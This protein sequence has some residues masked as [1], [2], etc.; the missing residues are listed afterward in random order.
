MTAL[1]ALLGL[2]VGLGVWLIV[3]G[4]SRPPTSEH[5]RRSRAKF[6]RRV[7]IRALVSVAVGVLV[8][9]A[10]GWVIG[11]VLT[12][13]AAFFLPRVLGPDREHAARVARFEAIA[14]WAEMLRDTL[15]AAAGLEQAILVTAPLVPDPIREPVMAAAG[16]LRSGGRLAP[17]LRELADELADPTADLVISALVLAAERRASN[18]GE[19]L[20][21]L[22]QAARDH[23]AL[24]MSVAA[25]RAQMRSEVRI[26]I[27]TTLCFAG[28]LLVLDRRYLNA[29]N[30]AAGQLVLLIVGALF[31]LGFWTL[32]RIARLSEP[33]RLLHLADPSQAT[34]SAL[35]VRSGVGTA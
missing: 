22:A 4:W 1:A 23:A 13:L 16:K 26:T 33:A 35:R 11:A 21:S 9:V 19:L 17:V 3:R 5:P 2:G 24:R 34:G 10:T 18:L 30:D 7:G 14:A 25:G 20:G 32:T 27:G 29:F 6:D 15:S 31:A 8:G 12:G 28:G